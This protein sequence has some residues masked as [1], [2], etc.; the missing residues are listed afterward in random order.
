MFRERDSSV[1][2]IKKRSLCRKYTRVYSFTKIKLII[3]KK[4]PCEH[5]KYLV[6]RHT[7][8]HVQ[9][10]YCTLGDSH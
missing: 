4:K 10:F 3:E 8:T 1:L 2:I 5:A 6:H 7:I 9:R